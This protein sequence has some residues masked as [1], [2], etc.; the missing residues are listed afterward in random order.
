MYEKPIWAKISKCLVQ[1]QMEWSF[2]EIYP[3][4]RN[5][6][7]SEKFLCYLTFHFGDTLG[8][9]FLRCQVSNARW[10]NLLCI[11]TN[12]VLAASNSLQIMFGSIFLN[13]CVWMTREI[14]F[15]LQVSGKK[16]STRK[17][18]FQSSAEFRKFL[19]KWIA[20]IL[21]VLCSQNVPL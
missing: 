5:I 19:P 17:K 20:P 1:N 18:L 21:R 2:P 6:G 14:F 4:L 8:F 13:T 9:S 16:G 3:F 15:H 10:P 12:V 11:Y 7:N